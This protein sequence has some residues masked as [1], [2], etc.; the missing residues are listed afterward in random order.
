[1][2]REPM[3]KPRAILIALLSGFKV[4]DYFH[5]LSSKTPYLTNSLDR[6]VKTLLKITKV[7]FLKKEFHFYKE[8]R[9]D[10]LDFYFELQF[11]KEIG[12]ENWGLDFDFVI[13]KNMPELAK[14]A[15]EVLTP[16]EFKVLQRLGLRELKLRD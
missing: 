2:H 4:G 14:E 12:L 10:V 1:M 6:Q 5:S 11:M 15:Q 16:K 3:S 13:G 8:T 9:C 7:K